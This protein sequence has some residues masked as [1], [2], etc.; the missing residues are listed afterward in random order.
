MDNDQPSLF[1]L[2]ENIDRIAQ[3]SIIT[4]VIS[5]LKCLSIQ[6]SNSNENNF[7]LQTWKKGL[8][9]IFTLWN[10]TCDSLHKINSMN[11]MLSSSNADMSNIS[12]VES[13]IMLEIQ[14]CEKLIEM[15]KSNLSSLRNALYNGSLLTKLLYD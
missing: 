6:I 1:E 4:A 2:P 9:P 8:T 11:I 5:S 13:F 3:Q 7:D 15:I 12:P 14:L 10:D